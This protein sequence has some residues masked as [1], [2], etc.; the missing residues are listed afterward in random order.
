MAQES[1]RIWNVFCVGGSSCY[2]GTADVDKKRKRRNGRKGEMGEGRCDLPVQAQDLWKVHPA[3]SDWVGGNS[4][5]SR[6]VVG[7]SR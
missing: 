5:L 4:R 3:R 2:L 7:G 1:S 6:G